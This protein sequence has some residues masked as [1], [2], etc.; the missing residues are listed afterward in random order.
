MRKESLALLEQLTNTAAPGGHEGAVQRIWLDYVT[1][2]A[3]EI[4]TDAYGNAAAILNPG[5]SPRVMIDAHCDEIALIIKHIDDK[6]YIYVQAFGGIVTSTLKTKRVN[7]HTA[8]GVVRGVFE[9]IPKWIKNT[10]AEDKAP[11]DIF[12]TWIDIGAKGEEDARERVSVGDM[13]T[14]EEHF[15][16]L[17]KEIAVGRAFDDK[18]GI[19][20]TAEAL[21]LIAGS[22]TP[23][24]CCV[25]ATSSVQ[26]ETGL[27]GARMLG[28]S[29]KPDVML[30]IDMTHATD[31]PVVDQRRIGKVLLGQGPSIGI[32]R[33]N[34]IEIT[35]R[36]EQV[37]EA[38][39]IPVQMEAFSAVG[40]TNALAIWTQNGGTPSSVVSVPTRYMHS[41]V[42]MIH[43]D[44]ME[45]CARLVSQFC[46][47]LR[48][49]EQFKVKI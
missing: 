41:T 2:Y 38:N 22:K 29:L 15:E 8:K 24:Q 49:D 26:E 42:E 33:E 31:T 23:P 13:V 10:K 47:S 20:V 32:G 48:K 11:E 3:D 17:T 25:I 27:H 40:G 16:M 36:L 34:H 4:F 12:E 35:K 44:D 43:L 30:A 14:F 21:R 37:A 39:K 5:A 46:L 28:G 45:N 19:W 1:P 18:A 7:I 9:S 6:G